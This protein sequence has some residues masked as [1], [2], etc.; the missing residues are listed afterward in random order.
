MH[1]RTDPR[2]L[3]PARPTLGL[4]VLLMHG[5]LAL[6]WLASTSTTLGRRAG[7]VLT[8][9]VQLAPERAEKPAV[10]PATKAALPRLK[11]TAP[12]A[13]RPE[14]SAITLPAESAAPDTVPAAATQTPGRGTA[15]DAA[16]ARLNL[17]LPKGWQRA[18]PA[19]AAASAT[20][21]GARAPRT[22]EQRIAEAAGD[23]RWTLERIDDDRIRARD[24]NRCVLLT[25]SRSDT[26]DPFNRAVS[27]KPWIAG[28]PEPCSP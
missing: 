10:A 28:A 6:A 18:Q 16:S 12:P 7:E 1:A 25:R 9:W 27:S 24:G 8:T 3:H 23:G 20:T 13:R 2:R 14:P 5:A 17:E 21:W 4:L 19:G 26:L 22:V 15:P 11:A